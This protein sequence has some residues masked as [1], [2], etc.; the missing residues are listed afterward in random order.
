[1]KKWLCAL[2]ALMLIAAPALAELSFDG[3]VV[4][5]KTLT[6]MAPFGG[7]IDEIFVNKGDS[8]HVGDAVASIQTTK[9]YAPIDGTIGGIFA[10]EGD[11]AEGVVSHYGGI[12]FLE[13]TNRFIV[14]ADT[15]KAYNSSTTRYVHI[16]E[17]VYLSCIKDGSHTGTAVVTSVDDLNDN[18]DT[19][20]K[21]EVTSGSFYMGETVGIYRTKNYQSASRIGRGIVHQN[22]ARSISGSGSVLKLHVKEGDTVERGQLLF[23]TVEGALDGLYAVDNTIL[24]G[25]EGIV[26]SV[27]VAQGGKIEK[28]GKLITVYPRDAMEVEMYV[29]EMDLPEIH[30]GDAV[31]IGFEWDVDAAMRLNG[32]I[33]RISRVASE[34][35]ESGSETQYSVFVDFEPVDAV[36]MDM[37]AIIHL[38]NTEDT[39]AQPGEPALEEAAEAEPDGEEAPDRE[40][41]STRRKRPGDRERNATEKAEAPSEQN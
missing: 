1:M 6:V 22:A 41:T 20:Y 11:D 33:S 30:E 2:L 16:G 40:D 27:E 18:G 29:S 17:V 25:M 36:S 21:L 34:N 24:S 35:A 19:P 10:R 5:G 39:A 13:P 28:N 23:E 7:I 31:S 9:V 38:L 4:S 15:E 12:M 14:A 3:K 8:I 32:T 26:A 37:S